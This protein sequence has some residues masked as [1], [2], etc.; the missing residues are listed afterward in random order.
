MATISLFQP[1]AILDAGHQVRA[2]GGYEWWYFDAEDRASDTQIVAIYLHGFVFHP[3][4]LREYFAYL[5]RPTRTRPPVPDDF[6]CAYFCVYRAGRILH[7]FMAQ[8]PAEQFAARMDRP[9]VKIGPN[10]MESRSTAIDLTLSGTPWKLTGMGPKLLKGQT[11]SAELAFA[12]R[13]TLEPSER[14]FFSKELAGADHHW[15]VANPLCEVR[16]SIALTGQ[17]PIRFEGRGYH[18]HNYGTGPIG[19]GLKHWFWGRALLDDAAITFHLA[20]ARDARLPDEVHLIE[21]NASGVTDRS[22]VGA[23]VD[24]SGHS[25]LWL[26]YPLR[27]NF[28]E[29]LRL[30]NP[31]LIDSSPFYLRLIYDAEFCGKKTTAFTEVAYPHRLRW[32]VLGRMI[33]MSIQSAG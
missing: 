10:R 6:A 28:G 19:P 31:R 18:D 26:R 7:Q 22:A 32:P 17:N 29:V 12:P 2:P 5:R 24:W 9:E 11:L 3:R 16:G 30:C 23:Q 4:Y 33:E 25:K 13:L 27:A 21:A 14:R 1:N 15:V 20:R 8:Y